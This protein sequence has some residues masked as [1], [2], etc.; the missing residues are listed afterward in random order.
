MRIKTTAAGVE[1]AVVMDQSGRFRRVLD[2]IGR[3]EATG[4]REERWEVSSRSQRRDAH[5]LRL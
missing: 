4:G 1:G 3:L 5:A 2:V